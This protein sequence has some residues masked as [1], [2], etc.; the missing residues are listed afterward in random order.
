MQTAV[1]LAIGDELLSGSRHDINCTWLAS[2]LSEVGCLVRKIEFIPDEEREIIEALRRWVGQVELVV[3]SGGLGPTHDDKTRQAL[4]SY[5]GVP[6]EVNHQA[7]NKIVGRYSLSERDA[8]ERSR[9]TQGAIPQ[10]TS[11]IHNSK[12]SALGISFRID[13]TLFFSFPGVPVEFQ[14]MAEESV[15]PLMYQ[16]SAR[17]LSLFVVGWAESL[18]KDKLAPALKRKDLHISIL[19]SVNIIELTLSGEDKKVEEVAAQ[20]RSLVAEDC[21]PADCTSIPQ[22]IYHEVERTHWTLAAAESCTGGLV[23]AALTDVPGISA[24]FRGS[25]VCYSN[26]AKIK[27]LSVPSFIIENKGAVSQECAAAMAE[28]ARRI[29]EVDLAVSVTGI[30]GP[31]GGTQE[32][33]VGTVCFGI[34]TPKETRTFQRQFSGDRERVRKRSLAVAL[35]YLWRVLKEVSV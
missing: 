33:P 14:A 31:E 18:L 24:F 11:P 26:E 30:A 34:A 27:I 32:K 1:L 15:L 17:R 6:L 9:S 13:K 2:K 3:L 7:Y 19:P 22:A 28:G 16:G 5:L 10:G 12:G 8:V 35:E 21:L 25:A 4:A 29:Y 23:G 20:I